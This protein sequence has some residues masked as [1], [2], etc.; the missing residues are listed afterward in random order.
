MAKK[1]FAGEVKLDNLEFACDFKY[2][3]FGKKAGLL[4]KGP[5]LLARAV[6]V[7]DK[8]MVV[9]HLQV[10][11]ELT[12]LPDMNAAFAVANRLER[13]NTTKDSTAVP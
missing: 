2:G 6:L 10:N 5:E 9:R 13:S 3:A 1:R 8:D 11:S 4:L 7:L 12:K